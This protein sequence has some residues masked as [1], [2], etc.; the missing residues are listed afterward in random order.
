MRPSRHRVVRLSLALCTGAGLALA[1]GLGGV[2]SCTAYPTLTGLPPDCAAEEAYEFEPLDDFS[3]AEPQWWS[4]ADKS[5][6][7]ATIAS[8]AMPDMCGSTH[9][10]VFTVSGN[11]DWG[12]VFGMWAFNTVKDRGR[13]AAQWDGISFWARVPDKGNK[14]ITLILD[15]DNT[16][17]V[18]KLDEKTSN[19]KCRT[20]PTDGGVEGESSTVTVV[21]TD[22][23][24]GTPITG[25]SNSRA[26]YPDECGNGYSALV[27]GLTSEW[28]LHTIPWSQFKQSATP[29]RVPNAVFSAPDAGPVDN[30]T[31]LL[32]HSLR[33]LTMRMAKAA[34]MNLWMTKLSFYR[35]KAK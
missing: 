31:M 16:F 22:P 2:F 24:T 33:N 21:A 14:S 27:N 17:S 18:D 1:L 20:Y 30:G 23:G 35:E 29:N 32:T 25:S 3:A 8:T 7:V 13:D 6:G 19:T 4:S 26:A 34:Q 28:R 9:A 5:P 11:Y 10:G 15:D 12:C